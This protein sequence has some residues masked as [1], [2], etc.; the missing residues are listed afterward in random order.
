M[1]D[2]CVAVVSTLLLAPVF[3]AVAVTIRLSSPGPALYRSARLGRHGRTFEML[4]FRTMTVGAPHEIGRVIEA[5]EVDRVLLTSSLASHE[6]M[7][8]LL[9][10][11]RLPHVQ[12]SVVPRYSEIFTSNATLDD[13]EGMPVVTLPQLRLG[14]SSRLLKRAFDVTASA[15][16]LAL[17]APVLAVIALAIRLDTAGPALYRQPRRGRNGSTFSGEADPRITPLG[18]WL[19]R[20][21][22]D[23]LP[24]LWNVLRGDMS[25]VGPRPDLPDQIRYYAPADHRRLTVRPGLTGLAQTAGR[26]ALSW[27]QRRALDLQYVDSRSFRGDLLILARTLPGVLSGRGVYMNPSSPQKPEGRS[28]R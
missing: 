19:R 4:K 8:D 9:R 11:L 27:E 5:F 22:L 13:V 6:E 20:T 18:R 7:L 14:R 3:I 24:Q 23:E 21:S 2:V 26:N 1:F 10:N 16:A 25:L 28:E 15:A 12:I 17:L